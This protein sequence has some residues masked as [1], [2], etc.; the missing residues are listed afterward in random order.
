[1]GPRAGFDTVKR[2][3]FFTLPVS[4]LTELSRFSQMQKM[5]YGD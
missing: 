3:I 1:M 2:K 5:I 4:I